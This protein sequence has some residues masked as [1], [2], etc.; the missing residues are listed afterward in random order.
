MKKHFGIISY[1]IAAL[2]CIVGN[3]TA[4]QSQVGNT[5]NVKSY[6]AKGDGVSDDT[7]AI[8]QCFDE[9]KKSDKATVFFPAG[10]YLLTAPIQYTNRDAF[11]I[12]IYGEKGK[13]KLMT[14]KFTSFFM[15]KG[16]QQPSGTAII[17]DLSIIGYNPP[18]SASHPFYDKPGMYVFGIA[19]FNLSNINIYNMTIRDVYGEG[20]YVVHDKRG[21]ASTDVN[22][23]Q[24]KIVNNQLLNCWGLHPSSS[25]GYQD[26]YG[27]GIYL[28]NV[29]G[30]QI[31]N[32]IVKN[33]LNVTKQFGRA[34]IVLEFNTE[35][36]IVD[37][38]K[39]SGYDRDIHIEGDLGGHTISNNTLT[40]SEIGI[41]TSLVCQERPTPNP[42]KVVNNYISNAG[43]PLN[44]SF[45]RVTPMGSRALLSL[46][47]DWKKSRINTILSKNK[48]VYDNTSDY[49]SKV[50]VMTWIS[51]VNLNNNTFSQ[52][53]AANKKLSLVFGYEIGD[54]LNNSFTN[55]GDVKFDGVK[56]KGEKIVT[57]SRKGNIKTA[58]TVSNLKF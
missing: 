32:N 34:G 49:T 44:N 17:H 9:A 13:S 24:V 27:D 23:R 47:G 22:A 52:S 18:F 39:V 5:L 14:K 26:E 58:N 41:F 2:F 33:D 43:I 42:I 55:I 50:L 21:K 45:T 11:S 25:G 48:V 8:Q 51:Y 7:K 53:V 10:D 54:L 29:T 46:H 37:R 16:N 19:L 56:V 1:L 20:I 31:R 3:A 15:L 4:M 12:E 35:N 30:A 57:G 38:N 40:G 36:C 28:S 6:G